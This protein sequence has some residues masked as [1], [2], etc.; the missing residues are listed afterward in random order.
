MM[1]IG[2]LF[3]PCEKLE[4]YSL[5]ESG[6]IHFK[7]LIVRLLEAMAFYW[8]FWNT[9]RSMFNPQPDGKQLP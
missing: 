9:Y 2:N 7:S 1:G 3:M 8:G 4:K 6:G 5:P